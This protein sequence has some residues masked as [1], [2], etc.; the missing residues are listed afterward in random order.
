[1]AKL[2]TEDSKALRNGLIAGMEDRLGTVLMPA[3][4]RRLF[5]DAL[6]YVLSVHN[7]QINNGWLS[8]D[9]N[10][11]TGPALDALG[12]RVGVFRQEGQTAEIKV[13]AY[14]NSG[15]SAVFPA[16]QTVEIDGLP[17][18]VTESV[19][20]A[21]H[22]T[23][24]V[25]LQSNEKDTDYNGV[26]TASSVIP[27]DETLDDT[28][29]C[30]FEYFTRYAVQDDTTDDASF[31][32]R[33][34]AGLSTSPMAASQDC[35]FA[36]CKKYLN[37]IVEVRTIAAGASGIIHVYARQVDDD[38]THSTDLSDNER[39]ALEA[40]LQNA[41]ERPQGDLPECM[42]STVVPV[43]ASINLVCTVQSQPRLD[44]TKGDLAVR[45]CSAQTGTSGFGAQLHL[46]DFA[47]FFRTID[48]V[49]DVSVTIDPTTSM[50]LPVPKSGFLSWMPEMLTITTQV[51]S[52]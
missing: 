10:N 4:E 26:H 9:P 31:R 3:D 43:V 1:M 21:S 23:G 2:I 17:W 45:F 42:Q 22:S 39:N 40:Y 37:K 25:F 19:T 46:S 13:S 5:A 32:T 20:I 51:Q 38:G 28:F 49:V 15:A 11:A 24:Y 12:A 41:P 30:S 48:G 33:V 16:L 14:N 47:R 29:S 27:T 7:A 35:W 44:A 52:A 50:A 34:L 8:Y 6:G 36:L 18:T